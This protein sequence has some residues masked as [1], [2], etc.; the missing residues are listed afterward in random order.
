MMGEYIQCNCVLARNDAIHHRACAAGT[1]ISDHLPLELLEISD[2]VLLAPGEPQ[3]GEKQGRA[4]R[5]AD[6]PRHLALPLRVEQVRV[7]LGHLVRRHELGVVAD[8][9][10]AQSRRSPQPGGITVLLRIG[11][12][13]R[14]KIRLHHIRLSSELPRAGA[15]DDVR[16]HVVRSHFG[17]DFLRDVF[18]NGTPV[19][20]FDERIFLA[21]FFCDRS[22]CLINDQGGVEDDLTC[23][24]GSLDQ[25]L[26]AV[27]PLIEKDIRGILSAHRA[28]RYH[29]GKADH[30][31]KDSTLPC[32]HRSL[33][34]AYSPGLALVSIS[35]S[36]I[37]TPRPRAPTNTGLRSIAANCP[38]VATTKSEKRMQQSTS[39]S[40]S[41]GA[42]PRN[43]S[44]SVDTFKLRSAAK[45]CSGANGGNKTAASLS[46]STMTPP[47]PQAMS[48]PNWSS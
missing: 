6:A 35:A 10:I 17:R 38:S 1:E 8:A 41:R 47:A 18:G 13:H 39:A 7:S 14:C 19:G 5:T 30:E 2:G 36:A 27:R 40:T 28:D 33:N 43:P 22:Q 37:R 21:E 11:G 46:T 44:S 24:L 26:L 29:S 32:E 42:A 31:R 34:H 3:I 23:L 48:G 15:L 12:E 20:Q 9:V 45:T 4:G 16:D 25:S